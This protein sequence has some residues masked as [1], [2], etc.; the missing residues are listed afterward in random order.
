MIDVLISAEDPGAANF[1][2]GVPGAL[3][4]RGLRSVQVVGGQAPE[5]LERRGVA[6]ER[7]E[8]SAADILDKWRPRVLLAGTA[9]KGSLGTRLISEARVRGITTVAGVDA[10]MGSD[11][12]FR[13]SSGDPLEF[14]PDW[15]LVPDEWTR[16]KYLALGCSPERV[17]AVGQPHLDYVRSQVPELAKQGRAAIR[18][19]L[20]G[21]DLRS[22]SVVVFIDEPS[23]SGSQ[24]TNDPA[25]YTLRGRGKANGRTQ[26]VLDEL[27]D[28]IPKGTFRPYMVFRIHPRSSAE[29]YIDHMNDFDFI[30]KGGSGLEVI[31]AADLVVG[32]T[33]MLLQEAAAMGLP[34]LS[35]VP[36]RNEAEFLPCV[37]A[38][39][40]SMV[41]TRE[42]LRIILP[43]MVNQTER[44]E[45]F[46]LAPF[47]ADSRIVDVLESL[48]KNEPH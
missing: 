36:D 1:M 9:D 15:V 31:F 11:H 26:I 10:R 3:K 29:D 14:L 19:R 44:P 12:R 22:Q 25:Q 16:K 13:G 18:T 7:A 27:L 8:S 32:M 39:V 40:T 46:N 20:F 21:N 48:L 33:S 42:Q 17:L 5:F 38:Q 47:G 28:S 43:T 35:I 41:N 30:S 34:T 2:A 4:Q 24:G 45:E 23:L 6:F 37:A